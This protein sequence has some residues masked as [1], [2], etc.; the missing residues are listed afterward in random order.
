MVKT[1]PLNPA[2]DYKIDTQGERGKWSHDG[3]AVVLGK[4]DYC[5]INQ[6]VTKQHVAESVC[7]DC[8]RCV[9][10]G[11]NDV[12]LLWPLPDVGKCPSADT[13]GADA[14]ESELERRT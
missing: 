12:I 5:W 13:S 10:A 7:G 14:R 8:E 4:A 6:I 2:E 1:S 11:A 3:F 9:V